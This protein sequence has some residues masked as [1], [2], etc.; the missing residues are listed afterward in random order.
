MKKGRGTEVGCRDWKRVTQT[1]TSGF[2]GVELKSS[3]VY[4]IPAELFKDVYY[5][6]FP[7]ISS[8]FS[9]TESDTVNTLRGSRHNREKS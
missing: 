8:L 9:K 3:L 1:G 5:I 2:T 6:H 4:K 7:Q